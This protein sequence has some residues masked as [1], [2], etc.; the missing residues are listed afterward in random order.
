MNDAAKLMDTTV[1][2][3][4]IVSEVD[5]YDSFSDKIML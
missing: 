1:I 3:N 4:L 5:K 2:A